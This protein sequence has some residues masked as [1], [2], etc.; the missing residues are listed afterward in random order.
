MTEA[1][2]KKDFP[3][4]YRDIMAAVKDQDFNDVSDAMKSVFNKLERDASAAA[5]DKLEAEKKAA[6]QILNAG[7]GETAAA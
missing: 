6:E 3:D 4:L 5:H 2:V 1:T 7:A